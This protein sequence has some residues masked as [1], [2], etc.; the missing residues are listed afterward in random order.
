MNLQIKNRA[1]M[2]LGTVFLLAQ[3]MQM[4]VQAQSSLEA[5]VIDNAIRN[6]A[7]PG[8]GK[9]VLVSLKKW[10]GP[11]QSVRKESKGYSAIFQD[12]TLPIQ[13]VEVGKVGV[14]CPVTKLSLSKA[15][16]NVREVFSKCPNLKP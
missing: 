11:Y 15:P 10:M 14:G 13:M 7:L 8:K 16:N 5:T 12:G 1:A 2:V 9:E 4:T 3:P 6:D